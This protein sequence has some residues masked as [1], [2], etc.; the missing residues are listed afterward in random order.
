MRT[1]LPAVALSGA[2]ALFAGGAGAQSATPGKHKA[3]P[4]LLQH[5]QLG[6]DALAGI[7]RTRMRNGDC[8]GALDAFDAVLRSAV[9]PTVSRDRGICHE[10]LG[11]AF[12]AIDDYRAYLT[13]MPD[14]ADADGIRQRLAR[15]EQ[16]ATGRSSTS[17]DVPGDVVTGDGTAGGSAGTASTSPARPTSP[18]A[19]GH[20]RQRPR[21]KMDYVDRDDDA[22]ARSPFRWARGVTLSPFFEEHKWLG[23]G[24]SFGDANTWSESVGALLRYSVGASGALFVAAGYEHF[25][26][27][28]V[29]SATLGGFTA[30]LGYEFRFPLDAD[31]DNQLLLSPAVGYEHLGVTPTDPQ[32]SGQTIGAIV[33]RV[34]LGYRRMI[35][36]A[37]ALDVGIDGGYSKYFEYGSPGAGGASAATQELLSSNGLV[38]AG[39]ALGWAL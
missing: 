25:N 3:Q 28:A 35:A 1:V 31:A 19:D 27:T 29:D 2:I 5:E 12:P 17:S 37:V 36:A 4:L 18:A 22:Q 14:A 10:Q 24:G 13:A 23:G 11:H 33:P 21:D 30:Q 39:V 20:A 15:L 6:S 9:D 8:A 34:R 7:G 32:F 26:A 38:A 16:Q